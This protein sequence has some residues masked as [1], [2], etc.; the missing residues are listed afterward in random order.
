MEEM[1]CLPKVRYFLLL[2]FA[3]LGIS[4]F[5]VLLYYYYNPTAASE[6]TQFFWKGMA[7]RMYVSEDLIPEELIGYAKGIKS[8]EKFEGERK[9]EAVVG[10]C[11]D[12][13][14]WINSHIK[15]KET[16]VL[17]NPLVYKMEGDCKHAEILIG[18]V[19]DAVGADYKFY[20]VRT[21][22]S[23]FP[24]HVV[25]YSNGFFMD[26]FIEYK[27]WWG[28]VKGRCFVPK[29]YRKYYEIGDIK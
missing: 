29:A 28:T 24:D 14:R 18:N 3:A 15:Y 17:Y 5:L 13:V 16:P 23:K 25:V 6:V 10:P 2:V 27:V 4:F 19:L 26:P 8:A 20:I 7:K 12:L 1:I 11:S 22:G 9:L 21:K